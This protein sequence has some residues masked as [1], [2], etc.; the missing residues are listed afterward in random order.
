MKKAEFLSALED[1]LQLEDSI[2]ENQ[3]L[4]DLEEW[5]SLS[6]M[7]V[8]AYYKKTFSVEINLNDLKNIQTVNDLIKLAGSNIDG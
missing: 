7:A 3:N 5:D 8:M 4:L 1:V 2:D 6:K